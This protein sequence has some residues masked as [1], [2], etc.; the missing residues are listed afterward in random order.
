MRAHKLDGRIERTKKEWRFLVE[1]CEGRCLVTG[2]PGKVKDA[3][4]DRIF[5]NI[6]Y[7]FVNAFFLDKDIEDQETCVRIRR[8]GGASPPLDFGVGDHVGQ[9]Y[10]LHGLQQESRTRSLDKGRVGIFVETCEGHC[11]VTGQPI[12]GKDA[13]MDRIF[14]SDTY[15][16]DNCLLIL[17]NLNFAK[18][19]LPEFSSSEGLQGIKIL[20][21]VTRLR[22]MMKEFLDETETRQRK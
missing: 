20:D 7:A 9:T 2:Q 4:V 6:K 13:H 3:L 1:T 11:L 16:L 14:N 22:A 17:G 18:R 21:S 12:K 15:A 19:W 10:D 8:S 5:N